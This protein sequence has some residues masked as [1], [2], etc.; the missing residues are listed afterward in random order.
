MTPAGHTPGMTSPE[1][2]TGIGNSLVSK[3]Q[4]DGDIATGYA[5]HHLPPAENLTESQAYTSKFNYIQ[6]HKYSE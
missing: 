5:E 6:K 1:S 2:D 4:N 3:L